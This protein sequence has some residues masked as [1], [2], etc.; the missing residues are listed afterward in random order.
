[1]ASRLEHFDIVKYC[2]SFFKRQWKSDKWMDGW[3]RNIGPYTIALLPGDVTINVYF[4]VLFLRL[5][6]TLL[7]HKKLNIML[8]WL[9]QKISM[10]NAGEISANIR[11]D[12]RS[13]T[14]YNFWKCSG[15]IAYPSRRIHFKLHLLDENADIYR[16]TVRETDRQTD[17]RSAK[18][19]HYT[20]LINI[21]MIGGSVGG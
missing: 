9:H 16:Q 7:G 8:R 10:I 19:S 18:R 17:V 14:W 4:T 6:N 12:F 3:C 1:M 2:T 11:N 20:E 13:E 5:R 21:H 15:P